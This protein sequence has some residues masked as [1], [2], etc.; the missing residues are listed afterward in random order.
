[1][2]TNPIIV[3]DKYRTNDLSKTPGGH[4]VSVTYFQSSRERVYNN[5]KN[6]TSYI[7]SLKSDSKIQKIKVDG[8]EVFN[9]SVNLD[10]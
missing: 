6:P 1:M 9:R 5:I 4:T 3:K 2:K 8:V 7:N 10:K